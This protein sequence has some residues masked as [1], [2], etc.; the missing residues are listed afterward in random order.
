[1][2][3]KIVDQVD[4]TLALVFENYKSLEED[5]PSGMMD[6]S[7]P[8]SGLAA[9]ALAPAFQ[10]YSLLHDVLSSEAQMKFCRYFQVAAKKRLRV[11]F[12]E[13]DNLIL[14]SNEV[15]QKDPVISYQKLKSLVSSIRNEIITD[16]S[17]QNQNIL[18]RYTSC[19]V[20]LHFFFSFIQ[21]VIMLGFEILELMTGD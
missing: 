10:L 3:V 17:I 12:A 14:S 1:M 8:A 19:L 11:Q 4:Q 18:P 6:V 9:P 2:L 13:T 21:V 16:I 20:C 5:S 7:K 15:T